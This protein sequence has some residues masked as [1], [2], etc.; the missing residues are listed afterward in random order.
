M[1]SPDNQMP[2][3]V[4]KLMDLENEYPYIRMM[5]VTD[6]MMHA[7]VMV[8]DRKTVLVGSANL[9]ISGMTKNYEMGLLVRN[10]EVAQQVE[11]ILMRIWSKEV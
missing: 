6:T 9:G 3:V 1:N 2:E 11:A 4:Q 10:D 7:K 8:A 5:G